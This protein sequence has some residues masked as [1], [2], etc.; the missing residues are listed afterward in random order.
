MLIVLEGIDASGK[1]TQIELFY[2]KL[3]K[4]GYKPELLDFPVYDTSYGEMIARFLRGELGPRNKLPPELVSLLYA[5]DRYQF[6]DKLFKKVKEGKILIANRYLQSSIGFQGAKF[7][8]EARNTFIKW[9]EEV[10]SRLPQADIV[11]FLDMPPEVA[12]KL[13]G[14]RIDKKY[15]TERTKKIRLTDEDI[16]YQ[17]RVRETYLQVA[18]KEGWIVIECCHDDG[19]LKTPEEIHEEVWNKI[20]NELP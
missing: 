13:R 18:K 14:K 3:R 2:K 12:R 9:L 7:R 20:K 8:G 15:L 1:K 5:A 17:K 6:K 11:I 10:E 16:R 4:E 19:K